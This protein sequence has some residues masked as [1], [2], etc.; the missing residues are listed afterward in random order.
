MYKNTMPHIIKDLILTTYAIL[1]DILAP[2]TIEEY[3]Y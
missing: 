2:C 3:L 1:P